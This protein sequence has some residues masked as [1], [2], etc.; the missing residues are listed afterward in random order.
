VALADVSEGTSD[1]VLLVGDGVCRP[2]EYIC[3]GE[4]GTLRSSS[5][6]VEATEADKRRRLLPGLL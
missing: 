5:L 2:L 3:G 1:I 4:E 6:I